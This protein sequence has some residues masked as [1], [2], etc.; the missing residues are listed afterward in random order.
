MAIDIHGISKP[1]VNDSVESSAAVGSRSAK[2]AAGSGAGAPTDQVS[3]TASAALLKEL[4]KEIVQLPV[5]DTGRVEAVQR[6]IATATFQID[7]PRVADKLLQ[8][9]LIM[10]GRG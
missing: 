7:P 3:L 9:E 4:E 2:P 1:L 10:N 8:L 6:A 5:V